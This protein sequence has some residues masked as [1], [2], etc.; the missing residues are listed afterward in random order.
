MDR[1]FITKGFISYLHETE[2]YSEV[3]ERKIQ[4]LQAANGYLAINMLY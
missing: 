3:Q 2:K 4:I 1:A